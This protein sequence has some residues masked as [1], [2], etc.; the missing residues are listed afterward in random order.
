MPNMREQAIQ[1]AK[2]GL[3]IFPLHEPIFDRSGACVGCTCE[4]WKR[5]QPK[6]GLGF[7]CD[8]PGKC[9]RIKWRDKS[10]NLI[11]Q[12]A[13]W[14]AKWPTA[15]IGID[16][17][18][19]SLLVL[20]AD[21]YKDKYTG[22][23]LQLDEETIT[24]LTGGGGSHLW[25]SQPGG[26]V[27]GNGVGKLPDGI[28]I[29]GEGGYIVAPPSLHASGRHYQFESGYAF[30]EREIKEVPRTLADILDNAIAAS[31]VAVAFSG[32]PTAKPDLKQWKLPADIVQKIY[33]GHNSTDRSRSDHSVITSLVNRQATDDEIRAFFEHFPL[34]L[35]RFAED[36]LDY[37][38]RSIGRARA[39]V[40]GR[41]EELVEKS[42][43][44]AQ[45]SAGRLPVNG[46]NTPTGG[47]PQPLQS[48]L[49][50]ELSDQGNGEATLYLFPNRF[51]YTVSHGWLYWTGTHWRNQ[52]AEA[53]VYEAIVFTLRKR[54]VEALQNNPMG[55]EKLIRFCAPNTNRVNSGVYVLQKLTEQDIELF[56][57]DPDL[58]NVANGVIDLCT[59]ALYPHNP[60]QFF[61]YCIPIDFDPNADYVEWVE[62]L[63]QVTDQAIIDY[64]QMAVGYS[65]TGHTREEKL[66]YIYGP[67]RSGKGTFAETLLA[68]LPKPLAIQADFSTF[69][70]ERT[71]D[72]QNFDLAPLKP[73]RLVIASESNKYE[74]LNEAKIK[75]ATGGD[76]IRCAFK[77]RNHFEYRPQFKIWLISNHPIKGDVDDDAFWGRVKVIEFPNSFLGLEDKTLK[78][79]M[80]THSNLKGVLAWAVAGVVRWYATLHGLQEP[81]TIVDTTNAR[82]RNLDYVQQ[83]IDDC[84]SIGF[85]N[86]T[87]NHALYGSYRDWCKNNG[88]TPK[89]A[90]H[91]SRALSKK[92]FGVGIKHYVNSKQLR[93]V[94]GL[95]ILP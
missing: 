76:W 38:A 69:T 13:N 90:D 71:G 77:H 14:W 59:G 58:L 55:Q 6:Y 37:L 18:K 5:K 68:L 82:R 61:T 15:N 93:G 94:S 8:S 51:I 52:G 54:I 74:T 21:K 42:K 40:N 48:L 33:D 63:A 91:F 7:R 23:D 81:Q 88:I 34:G 73:A 9:P 50:F 62:F 47:N 24:S 17:G 89:G 67:T 44:A 19:S 30:G 39:F 11:S 4:E 28:D 78:Q 92:G 46:V 84:C 36:G 1:Y 10:N 20:D 2:A 31:F 57:A 70:A 85:G 65:L 75:T 35:G 95:A 80:K 79:R 3:F 49:D 86:W 60:S 25:Y 41:A 56:D 64:L 83:W 27:F 45:M 72:T 43:K 26:K 29:R 16:C 66:F 53:K 22:I 32:D 12:I 87:A